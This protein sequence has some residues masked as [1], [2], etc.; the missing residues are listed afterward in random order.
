MNYFSFCISIILGMCLQYSVRFATVQM[1]IMVSHIQNFTEHSSLEVKLFGVISVGLD[2]TDQ[3]P[4]R[5]WE[6]GWDCNGTGHQLYT[7]IATD[8]FRREVFYNSVIEFG[9]P[10]EVNRL[11]K[12]C[13]NETFSKV[14]TSKRLSHLFRVVWDEML[15]ILLVNFFSEY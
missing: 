12:M 2:I 3:F 13:L 10:H 14:Y 11:I 4:F 8:S 7:K 6:G 5:S 15:L 1:E 9:S